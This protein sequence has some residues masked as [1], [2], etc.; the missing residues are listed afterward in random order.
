MKIT[1]LKNLMKQ[2]NEPNEFILQPYNLQHSLYWVFKKE[3]VRSKDLKFN[4]IEIRPYDARYNIFI[5]GLFISSRDY[6]LEHEN[7]DIYIK[8]KRSN[9]PPLDRFGNVYEI[10]SSDVVR[11]KG[12][13][14]SI[15]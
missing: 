4:L 8:F 9:V 11:I 1:E 15:R 14:E 10:E 13:I 5:N 6:I 2:I 7:N 3:N 12:D